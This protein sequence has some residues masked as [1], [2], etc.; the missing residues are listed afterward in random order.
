MD[1]PLGKPSQ[2]DRS[3][4]EG[5][6]NLAYQ[7]GFDRSLEDQEIRYNMTRISALHYRSQFLSSTLFILFGRATEAYNSIMSMYSTRFPRNPCERAGWR[8]FRGKGPDE[9]EEL[10]SRRI[11]E[12]SA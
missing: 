5:E 12:T 7:P 6:E 9:T 10:D 2:R 3:A 11:E 4:Q 1:D 8:S